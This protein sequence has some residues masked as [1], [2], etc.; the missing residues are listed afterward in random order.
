MK[1]IEAV[2]ARSAVD[3]LRRCAKQLG[4]LGFDL[5]EEHPKNRDYQRRHMPSEP[6]TPSLS[7]LVVDFAVSD[8]AAKSTVH[9]LLESVHPESVSIFKIDD[10][11]DRDH[12]T[13]PQV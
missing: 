11:T 13:G 3:D 8:E 12:A 6:P 10:K 5:I 4:I 7:R 1:K 9:A 2:L